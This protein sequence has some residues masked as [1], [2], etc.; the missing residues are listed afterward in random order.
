MNARLGKALYFSLQ[1]LRREPIAQALEDVL[2]HLR[3]AME[4]VPHYR[5]EFEPFKGRID[6]ARG[7]EDAEELMHDLPTVEKGEVVGRSEQYLSAEHDRIKTSLNRTSGST[8]TPLVFPCDNRSW[9]YRHALYFRCAGWFGVDVGEPYAY[10]WGLHWNKR[11]RIQVGIRDAVMNRV[12]VSAYEI[13][14]EA[15]EAQYSS[16]RKFGV[17]HFLGYPSSIYEFCSLADASG[18]GVVNLGLKAVFTTGEPLLPFQRMLIEKVTGARCVNTYGSVE[19]GLMACECPTGSLHVMAEAVWLQQGVGGA[20][21]T[22]LILRSFPLI[23]YAVGDEIVFGPP[24]NECGCGRPHPIILEVKGRSGEPIRLPNGRVV[25]ANLPSYIFKPM[26]DLAAIRKYRFVERIDGTL[27]LLIVVT[28]AF[29]DRLLPRLEGETERAFGPGIDLQI[30]LV[31]S[32]PH[33]PNAKH[34]CYVRET[35][36]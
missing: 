29:S 3:Y 17:T 20:L 21:A 30:R 27:E 15:F 6:A 8:G 36:G 33:L 2:R 16:I 7:R 23:N 18:K 28:P 26:A 1:R 24:N 4:H 5:L 14:P 22:D 11:T 34:R 9:A 31:E 25:N 13:G 12:R 19:G 35:A 32:I 10:F